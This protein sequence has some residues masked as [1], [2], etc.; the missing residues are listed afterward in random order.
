LKTDRL[1]HN[2]TQ[3]SLAQMNIYYSSDGAVIIKLSARE[4]Y[5]QYILPGSIDIQHVH[6]TLYWLYWGYRLLI[7]VSNI[8]D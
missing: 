2:S 6:C 7:G 3:K 8:D 1:T 5:L 4:V